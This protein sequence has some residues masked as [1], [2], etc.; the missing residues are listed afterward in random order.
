MSS[1]EPQ[2]PTTQRTRRVIPATCLTHG[3]SRRF[4][5]LV[6]RKT[7]D[8]RIEFDP[9]A[10]GSCVLELDAPDAAAVRDQLTEWLG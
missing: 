1:D 4:T 3:G 9:H 8:G 6:M 5:N 7:L 10:T 2:P